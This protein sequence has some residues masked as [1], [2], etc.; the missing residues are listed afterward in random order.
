VAGQLSFRHAPLDVDVAP[1]GV[2]LSV[3]APQS[4]R[5]NHLLA[6]LPAKDY[7]R[8]LPNLEPVPLLAGRIIHS[9]G[10]REKHLYF[11][12]AGIVSR[13]NVTESGASAEF[14][15]T[16][17]EGVIGIALFLGGDS[18]PGQAVVI[19][20]GYAYRLKSALLKNELDRNHPLM[21]LLLHY[22]LALM[23]QTAQSVVCNRH[24]SLE[25]RL[26]V[27]ILSCQDRLAS[28]ELTMTQELIAQMLG[29]RRESVTEAAGKLQKTGLIHYSRGRIA[30]LDRARLE[31]Q[32][33]ECYA[34]VR[35]EYDRLLHSENAQGHASLHGECRQHLARIGEDVTILN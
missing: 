19:S 27:W 17:N 14:A 24:H 21:H 5:Q 11:P 33:C 28:S 18:T 20:E 3:F 13:Y 12:T 10:E 26:C 22:T 6:A 16:G 15:V 8:L 7:E 31:A 35:R 23:A 1:K 25:Q 30:V 29:M 34:V 2:P 4:P 9:A 32:A